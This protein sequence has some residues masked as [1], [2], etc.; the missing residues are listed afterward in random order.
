MA[1]SYT[2]HSLL[3]GAVLVCLL[4]FL[5]FVAA[6][7]TGFALS[8]LMSYRFFTNVRANGVRDAATQWIQ[9]TRG[10]LYDKPTQSIA[11]NYPDAKEAQS[12]ES[13]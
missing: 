8:T 6:G 12:T 9:E 10:R 2:D 11:N 5:V 7:L 1:I 4:V 3:L 13:N